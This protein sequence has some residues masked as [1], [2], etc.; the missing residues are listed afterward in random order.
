MHR[1]CI[2]AVEARRDEEA[3]HPSLGVPWWAAS[4]GPALGEDSFPFI[5]SVDSSVDASVTPQVL[6]SGRISPRSAA[7][8]CFRFVVKR[9]RKRW[10]RTCDCTFTAAASG[11]DAWLSGRGRSL[12][13]NM[14]RCEGEY[15]RARLLRWGRRSSSSMSDCLTC[16]YFIQVRTVNYQYC[17]PSV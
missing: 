4:V 13:G 7:S 2:S 10:P 5:T 15:C 3:A 16:F 14:V 9:L 12:E 1:A 17:I 11:S 6:G 8:V